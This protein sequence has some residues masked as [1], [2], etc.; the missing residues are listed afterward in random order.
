MIEDSESKKLLERVSGSDLGGI[1][2][3]LYSNF[4]KQ[5]SS[6]KL[7]PRRVIAIVSSSSILYNTIFSI[8]KFNS[9]K[10]VDLY[11]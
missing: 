3:L 1:L 9:S 4:I 2:P 10:E 6:Y 7:L 8:K 5:L 11:I